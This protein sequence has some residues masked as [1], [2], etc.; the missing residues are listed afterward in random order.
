MGYITLAEFKPAVGIQPS[1]TTRDVELQQ[2]IDAASEAVNN[3]CN[4]PDGFLA[5][6]A[7][8]AREYGGTD[9]FYVYCD[10]FALSTLLE[11]RQ[12]GV[13]VAQAADAWL[14]FRG[15]PD[16]PTYTGPFAGVLL[17]T[18]DFPA[19]NRTAQIRITARWGA[20]LTTPAVIKQAT[21]AQAGRWFKR[22][23]SGWSDTLANDA[24]GQLQYRKVVDPDIKMM[25]I[26]GRL[27]RPAI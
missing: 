14:S 20:Y 6:A 12:S 17:V 21:L 9:K 26:E 18:G 23:E 8:D 22:G 13:Y 15:D 10:E 11:I 25:L 1:D 27:I 3:A 7:A 5:Q 24:T 4:R 19:A 2:A 16:E